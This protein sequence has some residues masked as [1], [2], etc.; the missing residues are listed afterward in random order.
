M[1][2]ERDA[3]NQLNREILRQLRVWDF[4]DLGWLGNSGSKPVEPSRQLKPFAGTLAMLAVV[5]I[6]TASG[7]GRETIAT[8][9]LRTIV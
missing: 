2:D 6:S 4:P 8:A 7:L 5:V 3:Q 9:R 1:C